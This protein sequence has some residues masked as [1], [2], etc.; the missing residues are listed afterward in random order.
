M[1]TFTYTRPV[2]SHPALTYLR[3][4]DL[5]CQRLAEFGVDCAPLI[6]LCRELGVSETELRATMDYALHL[7][8]QPT[9]AGELVYCLPHQPIAAGFL[10][11]YRRGRMRLRLPGRGLR[12]PLLIIG[13]R[14]GPAPDGE[15]TLGAGELGYT[16][17]RLT[18][19]AGTWLPASPDP[20]RFLF[21]LM[22]EA[23]RH[24]DGTHQLGG[25]GIHRASFQAP[26]AAGSGV[27]GDATNRLE[28]VTNRRG[29]GH[30]LVNL[31]PIP[32][33]GVDR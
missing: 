28:L 21:E 5:V 11:E 33:R 17:S 20:A 24:A 13:R 9:R 12:S 16:V 27:S 18:S 1:S 4:A 31:Y 29:K 8:I 10:P 22:A 15:A 30:E 6:W 19:M 2:R 23:W 14:V 25:L 7:G 32:A 3:L 26:I